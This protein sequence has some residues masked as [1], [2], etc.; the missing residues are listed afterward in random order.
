MTALETFDE[1]LIRVLR[2]RLPMHERPEV[3]EGI[4]AR[5]LGRPSGYVHRALRLLLDLVLLLQDERRRLRQEGDHYYAMMCR[6]QTENAHLRQQLRD[7]TRPSAP[8]PQPVPPV[9]RRV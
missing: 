3:V 5:H 2:H 1:C 8:L 4:I 7:L 9:A 6:L